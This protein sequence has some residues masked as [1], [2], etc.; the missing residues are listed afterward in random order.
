MIRRNFHTCGEAT[1]TSP[2]QIS[3]GHVVD[4]AGVSQVLLLERPLICPAVIHQQPL[5]P[6]K[7][8]FIILNTYWRPHSAFLS[9]PV[10][11]APAALL[12]ISLFSRF[13]FIRLSLCSNGWVSMFSEPLWEVRG[14]VGFSAPMLPSLPEGFGLPET[15]HLNILSNARQFVLGFK[16]QMTCLFVFVK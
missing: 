15:K 7:Y 10:P 14:Q 1:T 8:F 2:L 4:S 11:W 6:L 5:N 13:K 16:V 12:F 9:C 3:R